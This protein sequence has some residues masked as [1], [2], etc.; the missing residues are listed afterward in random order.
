MRRWWLQ[1]PATYNSIWRAPTGWCGIWTEQTALIS[2]TGDEPYVSPIGMR[3]RTR[4]R[5]GFIWRSRQTALCT[6]WTRTGWVAQLDALSAAMEEPLAPK[7]VWTKAKMTEGKFEAMLPGIVGF[8]MKVTALRGTLENEPAQTA[9][10]Y[11][12]AGHRIAYPWT[13]RVSRR[14]SKK[15]PPPVERNKALE[16]GFP[17][18]PVVQRAGEM[19]IPRDH[20]FNGGA[21]VIDIGPETFADDGGEVAHSAL[22]PFQQWLGIVNQIVHRLVLQL[23]DPYSVRD[24]S[25]VALDRH[26]VQRVG[27]FQG[28]RQGGVPSDDIARQR[29]GKIA[30]RR[31]RMERKTGI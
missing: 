17:V 1:K 19:E 29:G 24:Q 20:R 7:P 9:G 23:G 31:A 8:E 12:L 3:S 22:Q 18:D 15:Q 21:V 6:G 26:L 27:P 4:C 30:D 28:G 13:R 11:R 16:I 2:V 5:P 25:G 10:G 14:W